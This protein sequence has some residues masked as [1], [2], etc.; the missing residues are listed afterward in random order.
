MLKNIGARGSRQEEIK[1]LAPKIYL[2][3]NTHTLT[4]NSILQS[5]VHQNVHTRAQGYSRSLRSQTNTTIP[6]TT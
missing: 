2:L 3:V 5:T 4:Q 1:F 6:T